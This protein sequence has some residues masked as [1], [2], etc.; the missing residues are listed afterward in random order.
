MVVPAPP[1]SR[2]LA[3]KF[4]IS[5]FLL[6][7]AFYCLEQPIWEGFDEWAHFGYIQHLGQ[8]GHL[9]S[10]T[11]P[12][13]DELR[14]S[15]ELAPL[16]AAAAD[17]SRESVTHDEFWRLSPEDRLA[18]EREVEE[19]RP[20]FTSS[21][22]GKQVLRQY[23]AQQAPLYYLLLAPVYLSL[24]NTSLP[25]QV[26]ALRL[27]SLLICATGI[28]LCCELAMQVP[29]SRR[30][31]I[32]IVLLLSSWPGFLIDVSRIG[33]DVLALTLGS[34]YTLCLF[35]IVRAD[36]K[37]RDWMLAGAVLG[38]ALLAKSYILALV[39]LLPAV[40]LVEAVRC[41][42]SLSS[43]CRGLVVALAFASLIAGWW[44]VENYRTTGTFSGE[45]ID[46]A[47]AHIGFGGKLKAV[48]SVKWLRVLDAAAT[49]HI[50]T[51]GWSFLNVRSWMYRVFEGLAIAA[52][53]GL[54]ALA[55]R[56]FRKVYHRGLSLRDEC[57][58]LAACA[59]L[60]FCSTLAY[61]A[62][63]VYLTRGVS[64]A[65]GWYLDALVGV[66]AVL[67]ASGFTGLVGTRRA[68]GCVA[69]A[70]AL[71]CAFDLYTVHF[72]SVPYYTGLTVHLHSGFV[73]SFHPVAALR[74]IG[75]VGVLARFAVNKPL[76]PSVLATVWIGYLGATFGLLAYSAGTIKQAFFSRRQTQ[77]T[78]SHA[79]RSSRPPITQQNGSG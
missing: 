58:F 9:P 35:R 26:F 15:L 66:E 38:A 46:A 40:V 47:A 71:S 72:V 41:K 27:A 43:A 28:M 59:Y 8:Y 3:L 23:E 63:V 51:G 74:N 73:S 60:F 11:E 20:S 25:A 29:A 33:N 31:A 14:R 64:T 19:L 70:A 53:V 30:A 37:L 77:S 48:Q 57:L 1:L 45:Q 36:S 24:K 79:G 12:V 17:N 78:R 52:G 4:M 76:A 42:S 44:Y 13:S 16:S 21:H 5:A 49:T 56:W 54:A 62:I 7:G 65:P 39:P 34:A 22:L 68:A 18:R 2:H 10:R 32:P 67:L 69:V 6:R 55:A 75:L 50:W 61:L